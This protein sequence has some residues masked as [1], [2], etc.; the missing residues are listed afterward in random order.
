[1]DSSKITLQLETARDLRAA[2]DAAG[3]EAV[4]DDL[5]T[6]LADLSHRSFQ[7]AMAQIERG[8]TRNGEE[9]LLAGIVLQRQFAALAPV[10]QIGED[11]HL[12]Q[13]ALL[14]AARGQ[15][16]AASAAIAMAEPGYH[17]FYHPPP[18]CQIAVLD[19]LYRQTFGS[20][21]DGSFVEVGAFDGESYGNTSGL[22]DL[23]WRGLYIEPIPENAERCRARH[24]GNPAVSIEQAAI[25]A[26]ERV[27][28]LA[29]SGPLTH[30]IDSARPEDLEIVPARQRRLDDVLRDYGV[31]QHFDLLVVDVEGYEAQV[32]AGFDLKFWR[33]L[34]MIVEL[35]DEPDAQA[36]RHLILDIGYREFYRDFVN[37][38]FVADAP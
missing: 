26:D 28:E 8:D 6:E 3:A 19:A 15:M 33:P 1:M 30:A 17:N 9:G 2:G 18:T 37:T 24:A 29:V 31:A 22:A 7:R 14:Y 11:E 10:W 38:I 32:F 27:I 5:R 23:G 16:D 36:V 34:M 21:R 20:K 13:L 25:G 35:T 4:L 12:T